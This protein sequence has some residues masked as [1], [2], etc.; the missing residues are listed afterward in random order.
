MNR[1]IVE[2]VYWLGFSFWLAREVPGDLFG[3]WCGEMLAARRGRHTGLNLLTI[4]AAVGEM[5][6]DGHTSDSD[7]RASPADLDNGS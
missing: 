1:S 7:L 3:C 6:V 4:L 5:H 2:R